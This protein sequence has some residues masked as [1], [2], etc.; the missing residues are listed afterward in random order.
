[1]IIAAAINIDGDIYA[2]PAPKRHHDIIRHLIDRGLP[3]PIQGDQG[4]IDD[5][6]G[7]VDRDIAYLRARDE[8]QLIGNLDQSRGAVLFSEDVW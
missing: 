4:F 7:F 5:E 1:M 8:G 3:P 2:L 6:L